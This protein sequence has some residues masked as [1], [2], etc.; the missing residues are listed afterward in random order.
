MKYSKTTCLA[1][2]YAN[3][4]INAENAGFFDAAIA[5]NSVLVIDLDLVAERFSALRQLFPDAQIYYAV[6]ANPEP[7]ILRLL[8]RLGANFDT[9]SLFEIEQCLRAGASAQQIS[10]S[11]SIKNSL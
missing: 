11:N 7:E 4:Y 1:Q 6:K 5:Y 2:N 3:E 10:Y 9:A 8:V